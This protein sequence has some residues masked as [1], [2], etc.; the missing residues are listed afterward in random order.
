MSAACDISI[1]RKATSVKNLKLLWM[2]ASALLLAMAAVQATAQFPG[3]APQK[4]YPWSDK[5]LSPD[6]RADL[7]IKELTLDEKISLLHGQGMPFF[8]KGPSESNGGAGYSNAIPRLNIP[9]IQMAD[10]AYGVTRGQAAGRYSTALP[11]NLAAASAWDEK[12]AFEY[13]AL[14]GRELRAQGYSMS[15]GGGVNMPREPRNGRTFEY[16]GEDPLL[17]GVLVGNFVRGVQSAHIIGDLKH[18]AVNDQESGRN[19]VNANID[20][21]SLRETDLRAFEIA[22]GISDAGGVMCSYNRVNGDFACENQYLL[23]DVLKKDFHFQGFVLSDWGGTHSAVKASHAGLDQEQPDQIFF[24]AALKKAV[25]S[26]EVSVDEINEH[27][28]R[29]LRTIFAVGLYDNP[30]KTE[31][32]DVEGGYKLAQAL[33]EKSIVVLKNAKSVLPLE[34]VKSVAVIGGHADKG[35]LSGGGSA[36]VDPPGGS[37]VPPPPVTNPMESWSRPA[38]MPSSPFK[39]LTAALPQAKVSFT[40]GDDLTAAAEAAKKADVAIVFGYQWESEGSDLPTLALA[41]AQNQLIEAVAAANPKTIVVLETGS[42]A[43]MPWADKVAGIVEAWYPGIRGGEALANI[44]TGKVNPSGKLA[45]TFPR[46]D[47]DLPHPTLI[48]PPKESEMNFAAMGGD[49]SNLMSIMAKGMP[50]FQTTYDEKLEVGYKWYDAQKK[51][52]LFPFGFG[53]SYTSYAYSGLKVENGEK[54]SVSFTVKNTGKR[55]GVEI[56]Q[57]YASLPDTA[58]EPPKRLIGWARVEL[59]A[60]ESKV[61]SIPVDH[62]RLTVYDEATNSWKLVPGNYTV[63]AGASSQELTLHQQIALQ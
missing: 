54:L 1:L 7:V 4:T 31:V 57:I 29:I 39:A 38:W 20:K 3:M 60:G 12:A 56:A 47:A 36:Q 51:A 17:A 14:I 21:R 59:A 61:V 48:L 10:S 24:G 55:A 46:S 44:L 8:S 5:S 11:N 2:S 42:P 45:I 49:I 6:V 33:A 22:F 27:V 16:Q 43:T 62:D 15:L 26:G 52:V 30:V 32:P 53:L 28:H 58:G 25:E 50:A 41:P 18:Y 19:A 34:G 9:A 23:T 37:A 40:E 13:G 35:V 63:L